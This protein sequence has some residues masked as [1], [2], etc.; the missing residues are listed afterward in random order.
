MEQL[1]NLDVPGKCRVERLNGFGEIGVFLEEEFFVSSPQGA[2]VFIGEAPTLE[3]NLIDSTDGGRIAIDD[4]EGRDVLHDFGN[5]SGNGMGS[6]P[7]ELVDGGEAGDD[8]VVGHLDMTGERAVVGKND[9]VSDLAVVRDVRVREAK[10]IRTDAGRCG[11]FGAAM[12]GGVFSKNI[13]VTYD[14][15]GGFAGILE[16]LRLDSDGRE[17]EKFVF[18]ADLAVAVNHDVGVELAAVPQADV[19]F[20]DAIGANFGVGAY[21]CVR[22]DD[23]GGMDHADVQ[24]SV[25][26]SSVK[27]ERP[28]TLASVSSH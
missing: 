5:A 22:R 25:T 7:A 27:S 9:V 13:A 18:V 6:D 12:D 15:G 16:V 2:D 4:G 19:G 11:F 20:D 23:S 10:V 21:L 24:R 17:G 3:A 14:E 8:G 1:G 28:S 26:S